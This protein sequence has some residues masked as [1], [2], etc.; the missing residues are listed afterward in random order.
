MDPD[1]LLFWL[2]IL[3]TASA[4]FCKSAVA[5]CDGAVFELDEVASVPE[6][7]GTI[8]GA[9]GAT[10]VAATGVVVAVSED[11]LETLIYLP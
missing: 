8:P 5:S 4:T 9:E 10:E 2:I 3:A 1:W 6:E 11:A 7:D